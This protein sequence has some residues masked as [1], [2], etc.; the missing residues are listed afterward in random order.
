[1]PFTDHAENMV[2]AIQLRYSEQ[3]KLLVSDA[4]DKRALSAG[5][6]ICPGV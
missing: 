5:H 3:M 6:A 2:L 4:A 1:M